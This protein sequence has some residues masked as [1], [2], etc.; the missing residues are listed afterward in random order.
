MRRPEYDRA[1]PPLRGLFVDAAALR[2]AVWEKRF[3]S[4]ASLCLYSSRVDRTPSSQCVDASIEEESRTRQERNFPSQDELSNTDRKSAVAFGGGNAI[5]C[6][7]R[8][9]AQ[10]V[11]LPTKPNDIA[12]SRLRYWL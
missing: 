4:A 10:E 7:P 5:R 2:V 8:V 11:I 9:P 6:H 3:S 12:C 1:V